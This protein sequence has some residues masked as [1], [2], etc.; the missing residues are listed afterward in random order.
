MEKPTMGESGEIRGWLSVAHN[1]THHKYLVVR[2]H[3]V[4]DC[5]YEV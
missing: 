4:C 2:Q 1:A 5:I 3:E